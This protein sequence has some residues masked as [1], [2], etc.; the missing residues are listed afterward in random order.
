MKYKLKNVMTVVMT[1]IFLC[2]NTASEAKYSTEYA[3]TDYR[4]LM[5]KS[6]NNQ[7]IKKP[8][9]QFMVKRVVNNEIAD[10]VISNDGYDCNV[11][12]PEIVCYVGDTIEFEDLSRDNNIGGK[13]SQWD[14]Q[15]FG[16][17]GNHS[18]V[19]DYNVV[20][21]DSFSCSVPGETIFYL[22][23]KSNKSVK[24][25]SCDPWS[26]N[27]NHQIK[28]TN[29]WFPNGIYWYFTAIRVVVKP[30]YDA[31]IQIRYWDASNGNIINEETI[32]VGRIE[33]DSDIKSCCINIK[34]LDGYS[35]SGWKVRLEDDSVQYSGNDREVC[36]D[37][38][39]YLPKKYLDIE[40]YPYIDTSVDV[41]YWNTE[42]NTIIDSERVTGETLIHGV[43]T[44]LS[45]PLSNPVGYTINGWS[46]QLDDGTVQYTGTENP[47]G[48]VLSGFLS[49]KYLNVECIRD[50]DE[51]PIIDNT[52]GNN[53]NDSDTEIIITPSGEC[54]GVIE[55]TE[56]DYHE[57][58]NGYY[59]NGRKKYKRCYHTFTYKA[60]LDAETKILPD[61]LKSGYGFGLDL[62][63][64]LT[65]T[66]VSNEGDCNSWGNN[67][68]SKLNVA[69]PTKA[70]VY[71]PW[72]MKNSIGTQS[73]VIP[74]DSNGTLKF[75]LPKSNISSIGARKIYTPPELAGTEEAPVSHSFEIY[76]SGG[77][78]QNIEFCK[79]LIGTITVNGVMYDDDFSGAD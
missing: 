38:S 15:H 73:R 76:I 49:H 11:D 25:D 48:V 12:F 4:D 50:S 35:Y 20:D 55:W 52:G 70:T 6:I 40:Y 77:G 17:M 14:W 62:N 65:K 43:E 46:V 32:D 56:T 41:R 34:D 42:E 21:Q 31:K 69:N 37:L 74:M 68:S 28:G 22:C 51:P 23:V 39:S 71:I 10:S 64:K 8:T 5:I 1:V 79:K 26:D 16:T 44:T 66:L 75:I 33:N 59:S 27:G 18:N 63:C 53:E 30:V 19:Y 45:V 36:I 72:N 78:V 29:K 67:R 61:T 60:V 24:S 58:A 2:V 3:K 9:A 57:V 54:D 7:V 47:V 13:I